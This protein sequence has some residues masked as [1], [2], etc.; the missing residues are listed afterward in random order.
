MSITASSAAC[1]VSLIDSRAPR[2]N[3]FLASGLVIT[4]WLLDAPGLLLAT[5]ALL[6]LGLILGHR[7]TPAYQFYF[8]VLQPRFGAGRLEDERMPRFAVGLGSMWL[9]ASWALINGGL[10]TAGWSLA[11]ALAVAAQF[12]S[13]TGWCLGCLSYR[14]TAKLAGIRSRNPAKVEAED[15]PADLPARRGALLGF[16][17][18][19]CGEC[20][21]WQDR[22]RETGAPVSVVDVR[23]N[24]GLARKY[25]VSM[26]PTIW[27]LDADGTVLRQITP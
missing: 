10:A 22:L 15:R 12:A 9:L 27:E 25:G 26:V 5:S 21:E 16:V 11:L 20:H 24:P 23:V 4:A 18:P 17:H 1:D 7:F 14:M 13:Y 3:Q 6:Y 2:V 19:L 8:R